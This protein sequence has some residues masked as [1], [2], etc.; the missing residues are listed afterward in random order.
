MQNRPTRKYTPS[1]KT[2]KQTERR[3]T[4]KRAKKMPADVLSTK[5]RLRLVAAMGLILIACVGVGIFWHTRDTGIAQ[6]PDGVWILGD[7]TPEVAAPPL[8]NG[9]GTL[10]VIQA[11]P[12]VVPFV[13]QETEPPRPQQT[14]AW[15]MTL[16]PMETLQPKF[17]VAPT[18]APEPVSI[19]LTAVGDCT[20]GG[21]VKGASFK[22][23]RNAFAEHGYAYFL[24]NVRDI[25]AND[26]ITI[27]NLEGP[28]T[29][30]D[31]MRPNRPFNFK[32]DPENVQILSSASVEVCN[33]ANN[34]ALDFG[35]AGL[36]ETAEVLDKAGISVSGWDVIDYED[37]RGVRI[38]FIGLTEWDYSAAD[39]SRIVSEARPTCDLLVVSM[40]WGVES[41]YTATDLQ[42]ELGHACVDAGADL[43][44]GNHS[45]RVGGIEQYKGKYICYS[46]GNFCFGGHSNPSDKDTLIFQQRFY[47]TPGGEAQDG[48][49]NII[50]CSISSTSKTN[51]LQPTP[52]TGDAGNAVLQKIY[53]YSQ[54]DDPVFIALE[55]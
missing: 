16:P 15:T 19:T 4:H 22:R 12:T 3:R 34:H 1:E 27:V 23:F 33:V 39:V 11:A 45:H 5:I 6:H 37:V 47:V 55:N 25:L 40:H 9:A 29:T 50:P 46:L 24:E 52:L 49:I 7:Q 53:K 17:P 28:L 18:M 8:E 26:D 48:G 43:V 31:E 54:L 41:S 36:T 10:E 2:V 13:I 35:K 51:N 14:D 21:D 20:L 30:S 32:G 42:V 44:I 38:G